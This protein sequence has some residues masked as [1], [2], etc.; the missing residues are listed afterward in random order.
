MTSFDTT[1]SERVK[2]DDDSG[3]EESVEGQGV[4]DGAGKGGKAKARKNRLAQKGKNTRCVAFS[5]F[6]FF[7]TPSCLGKA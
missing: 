3:D 7:L 6:I 1:A 5:L 4:D 2:A